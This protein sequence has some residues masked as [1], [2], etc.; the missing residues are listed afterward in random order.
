LLGIGSHIG[1]MKGL[2]CRY[3]ESDKVRTTHNLYGELPLW[4]DLTDGIV[5]T[6]RV[7]IIDFDT[8]NI[9]KGLSGPSWVRNTYSSEGDLVS[10]TISCLCAF[11]LF[12]F[13]LV[14]SLIFSWP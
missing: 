3:P 12:F 1:Y 11:G 6:T 13:T 9:L 8:S 2:F 7:L 5:K 10:T 4:G 14:C